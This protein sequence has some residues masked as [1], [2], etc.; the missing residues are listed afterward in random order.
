MHEPTPAPGDAL[1]SDI[2]DDT[3]VR[4]EQSF[5]WIRMLACMGALAQ[6][7][8][9]GPSWLQPDRLNVVCVVLGSTVLS[10]ALLLRQF[11][12]HGLSTPKLIASL[13]IDRLA[14]FLVL[15]CLMMWPSAAYPGL[16][17]IPELA[18]VFVV[19]VASGLR[20]TT[21][22]AAAAVIFDLA[23][24]F[25]LLRLDH[26]LNPEQLQSTTANEIMV[27]LVLTAC[28]GLALSISSRSARLVARGANEA[29][30]AEQVRQRLG[31]YV[32]TELLDIVLAEGSEDLGGKRQTVVILFSD[33]RG[34]TK[35][36]EGRDP[37][38][39][40]DELNRYFEA[41]L[42]PIQNHG[43][44]VDKFMGDAIM[45]VWGVPEG[46][47]D[48]AIR[49][50]QAAQGMGTALEKHNK[51]RV[52][53]GLSP[54]AQGIGLHLGEVVAGNIGT[55]KRRQYTVVGDAVNIASRLEAMTK[56]HRVPVLV[57]QSVIDA[58]GRPS[59]GVEHR[60][61][62]TVRGRTAPVGI[63]SLS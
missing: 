53:A 23:M 12:T 29:R 56:E 45:A 58:A 48:D 18:F 17:R 42:E 59:D 52:E 40:V 63:F 55:R 11:Q 26:W 21:G 15:I 61:T 13:S 31:A 36:S 6:I 41:M 5:G 38:A 39:L 37:E 19:T 44:V 35:Y 4:G 27:M 28:G 47:P 8:L 10:S 3:I 14:I 51:T 62:V 9:L 2:L 25:V 24:T 1:V 33:L 20:L 30:N 49:A 32:S 46:R 57:S 7:V 16:A 43:G 50:L 22:L 54:L 60:G 34:F